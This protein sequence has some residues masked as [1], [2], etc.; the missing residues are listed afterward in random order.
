MRTN[1]GSPNK[2][3]EQN[4]RPTLRFG[5]RPGN[6]TCHGARVGGSPAAVAHP[7]RWA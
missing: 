6:L 1:G 7:S 4:R 2:R 5:R 3:V